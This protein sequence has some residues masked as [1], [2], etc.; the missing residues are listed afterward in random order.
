MLVY[1]CGIIISPGKKCDCHERGSDR[2]E[3]YSALLVLS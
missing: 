1:L 3:M 2:G